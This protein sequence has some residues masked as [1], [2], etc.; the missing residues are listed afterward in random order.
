MRLLTPTGYRDLADLAVGDQVCAWEIGTGL[1]IINQIEGWDTITPAYYAYI[2]PGKRAWVQSYEPIPTEGHAYNKPWA[3]GGCWFKV[4][5]MGRLY[6]WALLDPQTVTP[7]FACYI[8]NGVHRLF[9]DQSVWANGNVTHAKHLKIGDTLYD[10]A[11]V[12]FQIASIATEQGAE[13]VRFSISGDSSYIADGLTL[14]NADRYW[15]GGSGNSN[16]TAHWSA[17]DGGASGASVPTIAD[18][19]HWTAASSATTYTVTVPAQLSAADVHVAAPASGTV[20]FS[21][22]GINVVIYGSLDITTPVDWGFN[23]TYMY[24]Q[25]GARTIRTSGTIFSGFTIGVAAGVTLQLLDKF[26]TASSSI[27]AIDYVSGIFDANGQDVELTSTGITGISG[28]LTFHN[29]IRTGGAAKTGT[30]QFSANITVTGTFTATGY[31]DAYPL[32]IQSSVLGTPRTINAAA[33]TH[34][35]VAYM[36]ITG[37]GA[38]WAA[39]TETGSIGDCLGNSG[40]TFTPSATQTATGSASFT[41]STHGWTSRVPLPQDDVVINNAFVA[42]RTITADMPR[43]GKSIDCSGA[44]G[45]PALSFSVA[46]S[47]YGSL[48]LGGVTPSGTNATTFRARSSVTLTSNSK[49]F[50]QALTL[51]AP[52]GTL[53]LADPLVTNGALTVTTGTFDD[54]GYAVMAA[55][56]TGQ[57]GSTIRRRA[58]NLAGTG[59]AGTV[60]VV[61]GV[62]L[63][64]VAGT[65]ASGDVGIGIGLT[66]TAATASVGEPGIG[67][68]LTGTAATA[69]VGEPGVAFSIGLPGADAVG[70]AGTPGV[71]MGIG[72]TGVAATTGISITV[73]TTVLTL[74]GVA[75]V[76]AIGEVGIGIGLTGVSGTGAA[77]NVS[78]PVNGVL[79]REASRYEFLRTA[80][81]TVLVR[82][83]TTPT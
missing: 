63:T 82:Q 13:W 71:T 57:A 26:T 34:G 74:A 59:A 65:G 66:G 64:G 43:L 50:T 83:G 3:A 11:D 70:A 40:I 27:A 51:L 36:D 41:W 30:L 81:T 49:T 75:G 52:G 42:G 56:I 54:G 55:S 10:D 21:A 12:E 78:I 33:V 15:V 5:G 46:N 8:I 22:G 29:L 37:T 44:T 4:G 14:H 61:A 58:T 47:I 2:E 18:N 23:R 24:A 77:G 20:A 48:N 62:S 19:A 16:D 60:G 39:P 73:P 68:G 28:A 9:A 25:S 67:I 80:Q 76:S 45:S 53:T 6:E 72:L 79:T 32:L 7:P 1:P 17:S 35:N 38:G 31:S 69:S